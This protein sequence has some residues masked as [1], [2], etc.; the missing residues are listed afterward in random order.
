[1]T[2]KIGDRVQIAKNPHLRRVCI[3]GGNDFFDKQ[4]NSNYLVITDFVSNRVVVHF[5]LY[6]ER[7][8]HL[9][10]DMIVPYKD[11]AGERL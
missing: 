5:D 6:P 4:A 3:F 2:F 11:L 7:N 10:E 8:F 9:M 1:M